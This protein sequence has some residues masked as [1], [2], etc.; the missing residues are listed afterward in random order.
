M[1]SPWA[2][3]TAVCAAY[4]VL[5]LGLLWSDA[6]W[7]VYV[8]SR[9]R[10]LR[11]LI[12]GHLVFILVLVLWIWVCQFAKPRLPGWIFEYGTREVTL[13]HVLAGLGIVAIWWAEQNWLAKGS[14]KDE[15]MT[16]PVQR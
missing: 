8:G 6:K 5:V 11:E 2:I 16:S 3:Y 7:V 15:T 14:M 13:Y 9:R 1:E 12:Q 10:T 4:T